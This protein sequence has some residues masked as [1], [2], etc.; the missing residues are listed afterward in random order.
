MAVRPSDVK[1]IMDA[2]KIIYDFLASNKRTDPK[3]LDRFQ[4]L[5]AMI[6]RLEG[7]KLALLEE[8]ML[9][10]EQLETSKLVF[11]PE[12]GAFFQPGDEAKQF[13]FCQRCLQSDNKRCH[14]VFLPEQFGYFCRVCTSVYRNAG[15][16]AA[17]A[18]HYLPL[19]REAEARRQNMALG[20]RASRFSR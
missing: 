19:K 16:R 4:D 6:M 5:Q 7:D 8:S 1:S 11:D 13:P 10:K 12:L 15:H 18:A 17:M 2:A 3:I 20:S 9:L 14:L